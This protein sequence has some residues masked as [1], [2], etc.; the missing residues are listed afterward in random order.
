MTS[1]NAPDA[2]F[3]DQEA[4]PVDATQPH[5]PDIE[6]AKQRILGN[7]QNRDPGGVSRNTGGN[8]EPVDLALGRVRW[9][10]RCLDEL[11]ERPTSVLDF[12]C[13]TSLATS[14]LF[15]ELRIQS[16]LGVSISQEP[17]RDMHG[18]R[19]SPNA[20]YVHLRDFSAPESIDLAYASGVF[21]QISGHARSA[22]ALL[23]FL[24]LA[25]GG[26]FA[27]WERNPWSPGAR[28]GSIG[29][30]EVA[31]AEIGPPETR[32]LLRGAGFDIVHTTSMFH[33]P[34]AL[35][36][37]RPIEPMLASLPLGLE[38]MVLARKP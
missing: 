6:S 23:V 25:K 33:F 2:G 1:P 35:S 11:G 32:Q 17:L 34:P 13:S 4:L 30:G 3:D 15:Q 37:F 18:A 5:S 20:R 9:L 10:R 36:W 21:D 12:G 22:A 31:S 7:L 24:S 26:L 29:S 38:Y 28:L 16:F 14:H 19:T 27:V 8:R